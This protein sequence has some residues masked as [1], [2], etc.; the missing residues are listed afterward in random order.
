[1]KNGDRRTAFPL[2]ERN[3]AVLYAVESSIRY[4]SISDPKKVNRRN[5]PCYLDQS[6]RHLGWGTG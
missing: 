6:S 5:N 1:M 3:M 2:S 4:Y